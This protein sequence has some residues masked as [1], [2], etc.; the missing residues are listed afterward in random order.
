MQDTH[1][2][3]RDR[4]VQGWAVNPEQEAEGWDPNF[5][6]DRKY[7]HKSFERYSRHPLCKQAEQ[8]FHSR[9][10]GGPQQQMELRQRVSETLMMKYQLR[11]YLTDVV[12]LKH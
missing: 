3:E 8:I 6:R 2:I 9:D 7:V 12:L 5:G 4:H 11:Y 10:S 1:S